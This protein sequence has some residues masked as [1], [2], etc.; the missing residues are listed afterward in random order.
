TFPVASSTAGHTASQ[1]RLLNLP[2]LRPRSSRSASPRGAQGTLASHQV[3]GTPSSRHRHLAAEDTHLLGVQSAYVADDRFPAP[4]ADGA[5]S[6]RRRG[7][8][9]ATVTQ[10]IR[11]PR[12]EQLLAGGGGGQCIQALTRTFRQR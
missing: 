5:R 11:I 3:Q 10:A 2:N 7:D 9:A 4:R 1:M 12:S 6:D 8:Y